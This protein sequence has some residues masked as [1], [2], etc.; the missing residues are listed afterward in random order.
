[1]DC[2]PFYLHIYSRV[3]L[4]WFVLGPLCFIFCW[5]HIE[6]LVII[7]ECFPFLQ[8][9][10]MCEPVSQWDGQ[11]CSCPMCNVAV[12][13]LQMFQYLY[14]VPFWFSHLYVFFLELIDVVIVVRIGT[15]WSHWRLGC[16][17]LWSLVGGSCIGSF[18]GEVCFVWWIF[19]VKIPWWRCHFFLFGMGCHWL[20]MC[21][22]VYIEWRKYLVD[23]IQ[24][25]GVYFW[26]AEVVISLSIVVVSP[27]VFC[28]NSR[29]V[30]ASLAVLLLFLMLLI[31]SCVYVYPWV[32]VDGWWDDSHISRG[33]LIMVEENFLLSPIFG[34][35]AFCVL[36][37]LSF[38]VPSC[39]VVLCARSSR[40]LPQ[41]WCG[42]SYVV[43]F[44][45]GWF[46]GSRL[47][48][49][50]ILWVLWKTQFVLLD[51]DETCCPL[52]MCSIPVFPLLPHTHIFWLLL[53]FLVHSFL[54]ELDFYWGILI[55]FYWGS[56]ILIPLPWYSTQRFCRDRLQGPPIKKSFSLEILGN[57]LHMISKL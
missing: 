6:C 52:V 43:L 17:I 2:C 56:I 32:E 1:M 38:P 37:C 51:L 12:Y 24:V 47:P 26:C 8:G 16:L 45:W 13:F 39:W 57:I 44:C 27:A 23:P 40:F 3:A 41:V 35:H 50:G 14:F 22:Y 36:P 11:M 19:V 25:L 30:L 48:I 21:I 49:L 5:C 31:R 7:P 54:S 33:P 53:Y 55:G 34:V 9:L 29:A 4:Y 10:I 42:T 20:N 28:S 18:V 15:G 46:L